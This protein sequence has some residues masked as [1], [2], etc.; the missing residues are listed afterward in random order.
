[1]T[2]DKQMIL[3]RCNDKARELL[4]KYFGDDKNT[5]GVENSEKLDEL[6]TLDLP[7]KIAKEFRDSLAI[8]WEQVA[9]G[10]KKPFLHVMDHLSRLGVFAHDYFD[11]LF[12]AQQE[13]KTI[14]LWER[15]TQSN[16][17]DVAAYKNLLRQYTDVMLGMMIQDFMEDVQ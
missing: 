17:E 15:I 8:L 3:F 4:I 13:A 5:P 6:Y 11:K 10:S 14:T 9:P 16:H 2:M 12:D 1:M 7:R